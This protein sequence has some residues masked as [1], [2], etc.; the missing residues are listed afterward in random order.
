MVSL[1]DSEIEGFCNSEHV[2]P[3][4]N[5]WKI[6]NSFN[7]KKKSQKKHLHIKEITMPQNH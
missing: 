5:D 7:R 1:S 2:L 4:W 6:Y 3:S